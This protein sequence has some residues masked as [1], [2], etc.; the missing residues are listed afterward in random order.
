MST[1]PSELIS[2]A[3]PDAYVPES[4]PSDPSRFLAV[5]C[6]AIVLSAAVSLVVPSVPSIWPLAAILLAA[7]CI[8]VYYAGWLAE[9]AL[10]IPYQKRSFFASRRIKPEFYKRYYLL[11]A[12]R[13][14]PFLIYMGAL[15]LVMNWL[16]R[17]RYWAAF[18]AFLTSA[19]IGAVL[20]ILATLIWGFEGSLADRMLHN[21]AV[22]MLV[23][24]SC[25]AGGYYLN[26]ILSNWIKWSAVGPAAPW[27]VQWSFV[28][29]SVAA[30]YPSA[31]LTMLG[32]SRDYSAPEVYDV[33]L[34]TR[35]YFMTADNT[36]VT[37]SLFD[38]RPE[39]TID[40]DA[41]QPS[42]LT[43]PY[44]Q[45]ELDTLRSTY[46]H[47][48]IG[49][50]DAQ[51]RALAALGADA[52]KP[53]RLAPSIH[54]YLQ[55][56]SRPSSATFTGLKRPAVWSVNFLSD[57]S[58]IDRPIVWVDAETGKVLLIEHGK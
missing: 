46:S 18:D 35:F 20:F 2:P 3:P 44:T 5:S 42:G 31:V 45:E 58:A 22:V 4:V 28:Q 29:D 56:R 32:A 1:I 54:L 24:A 49:P 38:T 57:A 55:E 25:V 48:L 52:P 43:T 41:T 21:K 23:A 8:C 53:G 17:S 15:T 10:S 37:V 14:T 13:A 16:N 11:L 34:N 7:T 51:T 19:L 30:K 26:G 50:R 40:I 36:E 33:E 39:D 9:Q 6:L 47:I 27:S 12:F